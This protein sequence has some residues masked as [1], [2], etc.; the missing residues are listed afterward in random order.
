M[1]VNGFSDEWFKQRYENEVTDQILL[2]HLHEIQTLPN[3]TCRTPGH[4]IIVYDD[5]P[6]VGLQRS[7]Q[8]D[9]ET[10][11]LYMSV[12]IQFI[13]CDSQA[14]TGFITLLS[15]FNKSKKLFKR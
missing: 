4:C 11:G 12:V 15:D 6:V 10:N 8:G 13:F 3:V 14:Q 9:I 7:T 5:D 2:R 1:Y